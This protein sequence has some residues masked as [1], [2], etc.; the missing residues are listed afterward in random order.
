MC[1]ASAQSLKRTLAGGGFA[2]ISRLGSARVFWRWLQARAA[3]QA[4]T[5]RDK[6]R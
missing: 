5:Q 1:I 6:W 4:T 3:P 2:L